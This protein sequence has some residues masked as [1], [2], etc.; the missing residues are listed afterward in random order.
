MELSTLS[1]SIFRAQS[2]CI[3][4]IGLGTSELTGENGIKAI[5]YAIQTGY[6]LID[7]AFMYKNEEIVG[8]AVRQAVNEGKHFY[9]S[10]IQLN[11]YYPKNDSD[12]CRF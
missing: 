4:A 3:P 11:N 6:R 7:T 12:S 8:E 9:Q 10:E 1:E 2:A 5:K